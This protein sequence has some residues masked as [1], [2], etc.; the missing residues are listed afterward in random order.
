[1]RSYATLLVCNC[2]WPLVEIV[3]ILVYVLSPGGV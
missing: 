1:L 3:C 2:V